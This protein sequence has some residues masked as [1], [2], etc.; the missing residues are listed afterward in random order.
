[1]P[2]L[3]GFD[4]I[5]SL[6]SNPITSHIPI[7]AIT[8]LSSANT[9]KRLEESGTDAILTKP[10]DYHELIALIEKTITT[11]RSTTEPDIGQ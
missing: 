2:D 3:D 7:I 9:M 10:V 4:V 1:M 5:Q 8:G 11:P 6:K